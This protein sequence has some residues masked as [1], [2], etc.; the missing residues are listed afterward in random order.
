MQNFKKYITENLNYYTITISVDVTK[1]MSKSREY[2]DKIASV[3]LEKL[4]VS[5]SGIPNTTSFVFIIK[6]KET[7]SKTFIAD[8]IDIV[9]ENLPD[10]IK[11]KKDTIL[12]TSLFYSHLPT[13]NVITDKVKVSINK[14]QSLSG[15]YKFVEGCKIVEID[16]IDYVTDG[17]LGLLTL[18]AKVI[19]SPLHGK[20]NDTIKTLL[21]ILHKHLNGK[22]DVIACQ[23][24]LIEAG[25]KDYAKF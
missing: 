24:E 9:N 12:T 25:L 7:L 5:V 21:S 19:L 10:D 14:K 2:Y 22:N 20:V 23:E 18:K 11:V 8:F 13:E 16:G 1:Y 6:V 17:V 15:F 4:G 3:A